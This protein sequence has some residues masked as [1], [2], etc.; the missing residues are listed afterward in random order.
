[1]ATQSICILRLSAIGDVTHVL[2]VINAI[3]KH[4]PQAKITWIIG[5]LE[6]R[7]LKDFE[8]VEFIVFD[9]KGGFDAVRQ[10][11]KTLKGRRFDVLLHMQVAARA[12]LLSKLIKA[13]I[14]DPRNGICQFPGKTKTG[15]GRPWAMAHRS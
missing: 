10:L 1:V 11:R 14:R 2:P 3:R 6:A 7:L 15:P 13:P 9:K 12:N 5:K 8:G 4:Q